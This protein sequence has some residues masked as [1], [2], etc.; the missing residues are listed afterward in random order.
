M[1]AE[2]SETVRQIIGGTPGEVLAKA[3][4]SA[5]VALWNNLQVIS[6]SIFGFGIL[7][8]V[9]AWMGAIVARRSGKDFKP[10]K[11]IAGPAKKIVMTAA[12]LTCTQVVD[13]MLP[14]ASW[15]PDSPLFFGA[16]AFIAV[17]QLL[18]VAKKYGTLSGSKVANWIE[19][20]LGTFIK[21]DETPK[22]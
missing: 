17:T 16:A 14:K 2:A 21:I 7:L 22:P 4:I 18:D 6:G 13:T 15:L 3:M 11:F 20:K 12:M 9:D 8:V 1:K 19:Q 5:A 10:G